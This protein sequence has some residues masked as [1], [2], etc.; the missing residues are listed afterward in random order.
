MKSFTKIA[1]GGVAIAGLL[2]V[3]GCSS[4]GSAGETLDN[5]DAKDV[6][7]A[8]FNGW[9]EGIAASELWKAILEDKGYDVELEYAD[10]AP[11]YQGLS[12]ND[13]DLTLDTWLPA[14]HKSYIDKYGDKM[15]DLGS[16]N[17][18]AKL[19]IA[20]NEDAPI[21]SL[22][23]LAANADAFGNKLVGIEPGAGLTE[24]TTDKVIPEYGLDGFDYVTSSTPAML[25]ELKAATGKGDNV[26]V[27]LWRPHWA[28]DAF[29]IKDL[30]DPKGALGGAEGI[31][32][33]GSNEFEEKFP[34]LSGWLK[35]FKMDN[36]HL[37]ALENVM[38]NESDSDDY[39]PAVEK[40]IADNKDFVDGLTK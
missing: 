30:E 29:P 17:D 2:G 35:D 28:Y 33:F 24:V 13:Y 1:L 7:I 10:P 18:E 31:H 23:E 5:G 36:E 3:A 26:A 21:D 20:V 16:W 34:T 11:V 40:W 12:D 9:D 14:T 8:V 22:D 25:S 27:T 39:G 37:Y 19:T 38:F 32:S 4:S 6:K 15:I